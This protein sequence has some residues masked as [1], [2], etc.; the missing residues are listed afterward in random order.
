M[1]RVPPTWIVSSLTPS[2][3]SEDQRYSVAGWT[4]LPARRRGR[5]EQAS[6]RENSLSEA[7]SIMR[8]HAVVCVGTRMIG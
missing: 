3:P 1:Q 5:Q 6:A 8:V 2:R 7:R 4:G